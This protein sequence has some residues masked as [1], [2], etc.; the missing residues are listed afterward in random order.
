MDYGCCCV[1]LKCFLLYSTI[2]NI[3]V[4]DSENLNKQI[5]KNLFQNKHIL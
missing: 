1:L 3:S 5:A 2:L 4:S